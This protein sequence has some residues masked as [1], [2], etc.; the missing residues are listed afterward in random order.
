MARVLIT[1]GSGFLG[2]HVT[3]KAIAAGDSVTVFDLTP[4]PY[5]EP[6]W[7]VE[8]IQGDVRDVDRLAALVSNSD[9][10]VHLAGILGTA[11]TVADP[12]PSLDVN[13]KASLHLYGLLRR[14][15][16]PAVVTVNG[17]HQWFNTYAIT[18]EAA[19]RF[20]IMYNRE[21]G[22]RIAVCRVYNAYGE[23]QKDRPVRKVVPEFARR[24]IH[25]E[26][27]E[28]FGTGHQEFDL[29]YAGDV[30]DALYR[31]VTVDHRVY[32]HIMEIG[33]GETIT[34]LG[35]ASEIIDILGSKS[36]IVHLHMRSGEPEV[37]FLRAELESSKPLGYQPSVP[38]EDGLRRTVYWYQGYFQ[39]A[40]AREPFSDASD[41]ILRK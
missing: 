10:I 18:K 11:E 20:A 25:G 3:A 32:D 35:L 16:R 2:A 26:P 5:V 23:W 14:N 24:A 30:A 39:R 38:I 27:I 4:P 9:R 21:F 6:G 34:P 15:D 22:T 31:A 12:L 36:P 7:D 40:A 28:I 1:G 13:T 17:N 8:F 37:S 19:G 29:V 33:S 41:E